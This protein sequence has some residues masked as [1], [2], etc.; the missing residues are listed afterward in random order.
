MSTDETTTACVVGAPN[1]LRAAANVQPLIAATVARIKPNTT[2]L[3][4]PCITSENCSTAMARS[5]KRGGVE[6]EGE[7]AG[8]HAADETDEN[9]DGCE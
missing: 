4:K 7:H 3:D 8:Y 5:Q 6:A 9:R 2:D 1:P